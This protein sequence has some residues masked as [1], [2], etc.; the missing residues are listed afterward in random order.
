MLLSKTS[1]IP[2]LS[3]CLM[4]TFTYTLQMKL[5]SDHKFIE[6]TEICQAATLSQRMCTAVYPC[7]P[8]TPTPIPTRFQ[9]PVAFF[10][11]ADESDC[12]GLALMNWHYY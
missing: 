8:P 4:E 9:A 10:Y 1:V 2:K 7:S 6:G 5:I 12:L 11:S 3:L